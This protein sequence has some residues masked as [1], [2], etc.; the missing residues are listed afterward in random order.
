[1]EEGGTTYYVIPDDPEYSGDQWKSVKQWTVPR[2]IDTLRDLPWEAYNKDPSVSVKR[3]VSD[4]VRGFRAN[5]WLVPRGWKNEGNTDFGRP[6]YFR[7]A[8]QFN[9]VMNGDLKIQAYRSPKQRAESK[10]LG[11]YYYF[12]RPPMSILGLADGVVSNEGCVW[13]EVT[14]AKGTSI[15]N[16]PIEDIT[17]V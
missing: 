1:M 15:P 9:F 10:V 2:I 5:L 17:F 13:L 6:Y 8:H 12:E 7:D 11:P 4:Q 14:Y 3:L 16:V